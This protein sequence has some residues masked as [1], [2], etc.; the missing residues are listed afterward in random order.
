MR[1]DSNNE[2]SVPK[3]FENVDNSNLTPRMQKQKHLPEL[4]K[5]PV[6]KQKEHLRRKLEQDEKVKENSLLG[7]NPNEALRYSNPSPKSSN[8]NNN[9]SP[10][11]DVHQ[12]PRQGHLKK[13]GNGSPELGYEQPPKCELSG[14]EAIS[15]VSRAKSKQCRQEIAEVYCRHKEGKLMPEEVTRFCP[16]EGRPGKRGRGAMGLQVPVPFL[17]LSIQSHCPKL[18]NHN[19]HHN[20]P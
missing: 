3:D 4:V 7:K 9:G 19:S 6:S 11:K 17:V 10:F 12:P 18:E 5:K 16:L 8:N 15:A 1:T 20:S 2:N 14:K 13:S